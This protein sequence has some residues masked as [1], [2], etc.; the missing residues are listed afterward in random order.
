M[1]RGERNGMA[2]LGWSFFFSIWA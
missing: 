1:K 2:I